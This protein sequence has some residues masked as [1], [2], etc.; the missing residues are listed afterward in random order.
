MTPPVVAICPAGVAALGMP[1]AL[2]GAD[3]VP[4]VVAFDDGVVCAKA[5][6]LHAIKAAAAM[7]DIL[8]VG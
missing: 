8:I 6:T 5:E 4:N 7:I 2:P 1:E 3:S